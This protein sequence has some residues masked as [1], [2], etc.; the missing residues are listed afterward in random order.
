MRHFA[1]TILFSAMAL[2]PTGC[3]SSSETASRDT[4]TTH[5][6]RYDMPPAGLKRV[7]VGV[8]PF[9]IE[10]KVPQNNW[11]RTELARD[12]ADQL[13]TLA[14]RTDRFEVIERAQ[15][16]QLLKE[17][18]L[19]GI[20]DPNEL[21]RPGR[22]RGVDYLFIGKITNMRVKAERS[23]SG[24]GILIVAWRDARTRITIECG[25][26]LRLVNPTNG[27]VL[28]SEFAEYK[29]TDSIRALG[30][31]VLGLVGGGGAVNM[32]ISEDSRGKILRLALDDCV[33]KMVQSGR[34][35][36]RLREKQQ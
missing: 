18:G 23:R 9:K 32:R 19:E 25:V 20:V 27:S 14:D 6:G 16:D 10:R 34:L 22:V 8:P 3:T 12:A 15:L 31:N 26:D 5:V 29:R 13:T 11:N 28:I 2:A 33:R 4:M 1:T 35:D 30:V 24:A 21:A 36:R 7:R 17:Q